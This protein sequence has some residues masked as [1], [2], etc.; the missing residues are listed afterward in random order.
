VEHQRFLLHVRN[1]TSIISRSDDKTKLRNDGWY[2]RSGMRKSRRTCVIPYLPSRQF[3]HELNG[4]DDPWYVERFPLGLP[5]TAWQLKHQLAMAH[6]ESDV[7]VLE[8]D[9]KPLAEN[10]KP[11]PSRFPFRRALRDR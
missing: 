3:R 8:L 1:F 5:V 9:T 11:P 2:V 7:D 10:A 6:Q 4:Q